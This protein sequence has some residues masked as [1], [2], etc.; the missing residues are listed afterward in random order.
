MP[1]KR[2]DDY[3]RA[4]RA[5]GGIV[6]VLPGTTTV[7][8][9]YPSAVAVPL[10]NARKLPPPDSYTRDGQ[11]A[12]FAARDYGVQLDAREFVRATQAEAHAA[13]LQLQ[14]QWADTPL[15]RVFAQLATLGKGAV[16]VGLVAVV[17]VAGLFVARVRR[18]I[19]A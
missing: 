11:H 19:N 5:A 8:A 16:W 7:A 1:S 15:G 3:A 4:V 17:V 14:Q 12:Y 18:E 6:T 2:Y 13:G 10:V 9:R